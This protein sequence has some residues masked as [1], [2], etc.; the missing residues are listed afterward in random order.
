VGA[1]GSGCRT[2]RQSR[3]QVSFAASLDLERCDRRWDIV[4]RG[5][6]QGKLPQPFS[7]QICVLAFANSAFNDAC[8]GS[9][10]TD[11]VASKQHPYAN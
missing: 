10:V 9:D 8:L 4:M 2:R 7:G 5:T 11:A 1:H 6:W 3:G